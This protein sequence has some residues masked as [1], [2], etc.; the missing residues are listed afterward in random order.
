M[1]SHGVYYSKDDNEGNSHSFTKFADQRHEMKFSKTIPFSWLALLFFLFSSVIPAATFPLNSPEASQAEKASLSIQ[2]TGIGI[3]QEKA[4]ANAVTNAIQQAVG[5]YVQAETIVA[6][7]DII[8]DELLSYSAG[9]VES[10]N[11]VQQSVDNDGL[12]HVEIL[13]IVQSSQ[14]LEKLNALNIAVRRIDGASL[15]VKSDTQ[16]TMQEQ[17]ANLLAGIWEQYP[18]AAYQIKI[19]QVDSKASAT[20][21]E[22]TTLTIKGS[23]QIDGQFIQHLEEI[24]GQVDIEKKENIKF[25]RVLKLH[26]EYESAVS[27]LCFVNKSSFRVPT[28]PHENHLSLFDHCYVV[29]QEIFVRGL[30]DAGL[31]QNKN[32]GAR[33]FYFNRGDGWLWTGHHGDLGESVL[34]EVVDQNENTLAKGISFLSGIWGTV[35]YLWKDQGWPFAYDA[36][37]KSD[38]QYRFLFF[39]GAELPF[40]ISIDVQTDRIADATGVVLS[41]ID[42]R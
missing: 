33:A 37:W 26:D 23:I 41:I 31:F 39:V 7:N 9:Y 20:S 29:D 19:D 14:L 42:F 27:V 32:S 17:G 1:T 12:H 15:A 25:D 8:K 11:V 30:T 16:R 3:S 35:S 5:Q 18:S 2:S 40:Y 6:N 4:V 10:Y 24:L 38:K 22:M 28:N 13:A 34:V 21:S 36:F